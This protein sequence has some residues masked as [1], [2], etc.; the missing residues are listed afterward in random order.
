MCHGIQIGEG[1]CFAEFTSFVDSLTVSF[2]NESDGEFNQVFWQFDDQGS[3]NEYNPTFIFDEPGFYEVTMTISEQDEA[4]NQTGNCNN[5]VTKLI[6]V[7]EVSQGGACYA[8]FN[9]FIEDTLMAFNNQSQGNFTEA[10]WTFIDHNNGEQF[11]SDEM[12]PVLGAWTW[13]LRSVYYYY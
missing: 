2:T 12:N 6:Q 7:G 9:F 4:G 11:T 10:F 5:S 3:S 8:D 13:F 1:G